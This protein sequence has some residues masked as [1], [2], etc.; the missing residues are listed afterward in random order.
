MFLPLA[1]LETED[2]LGFVAD[3]A[4]FAQW[5]RKWQIRSSCDGVTNG[6]H[7][8]SHFRPASLA[9]AARLTFYFPFRLS[10]AGNLK[11]GVL[12][13]A[14]GALP[15]CS[16]WH[17]RL[18]DRLKPTRAASEH[19]LLAAAVLSNTE[20]TEFAP[21]HGWSC[22]RRRNHGSVWVAPHFKAVSVARCKELE[23]RL[24]FPTEVCSAVAATT[25]N[26]GTAFATVTATSAMCWQR[27]DRCGSAARDLNIRKLFRA[28]AKK[29]SFPI[30]THDIYAV[31]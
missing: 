20:A 23:F 28:W 14:H 26:D 1:L 13:S 27:W 4:L 11:Y 5:M 6:G 17:W 19:H 7:H 22:K 12:K 24:I 15:H 18:L 16:A 21:P 8:V 25:P 29:L 10:T 2:R 9:V 31:N 3:G 30:Q